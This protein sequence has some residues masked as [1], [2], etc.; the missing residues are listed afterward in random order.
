MKSLA[1][2][3]LSLLLAAPSD[4]TRPVYLGA[5]PVRYYHGET[6]GVVIYSND[7][8]IA[9]GG[10]YADRIVYGCFNYTKK[11]VPV[12]VLP[13]PCLWAEREFYATL[14]CHEASHQ[15]GWPGDHPL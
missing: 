2:I 3:P 12:T 15:K 6:V 10:P 14:A 11:G 9:C 13:N 4:S 8:E 7:P 1:I 5:P